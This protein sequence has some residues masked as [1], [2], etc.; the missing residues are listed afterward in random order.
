MT[1]PNIVRKH[2]T[3]STALP[4]FDAG[5]RAVTKLGTQV[6]TGYVHMGTTVA[7]AAGKSLTTVQQIAGRLWRQVL[8]ST[9][10]ASGRGTAGDSHRTHRTHRTE[11]VKPGKIKTPITPARP[12]PAPNGPRHTERRYSKTGT[13][14]S[15]T[16]KSDVA[17]AAK[18]DRV[19]A[20]VDAY[21]K[22]LALVDEL[23]KQS[24]IPSVEEQM[25]ADQRATELAARRSLARHF[26]NRERYPRLLAVPAVAASTDKGPETPVVPVVIARAVPRPAN[27]RVLLDPHYVIGLYPDERPSLPDDIADMNLK[28]T[29]RLVLGPGEA[30]RRSHG[31]IA[32]S[33]RTDS[34]AFVVGGPEARA[35]RRPKEDGA[36]VSSTAQGLRE[37]I[38][39]AAT[40][41]PA[42]DAQPVTPVTA[43]PNPTTSPAASR[44]SYPMG[45]I[46]L[47]GRE[48]R[49]SA[50]TGQRPF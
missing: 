36:R 29:Q 42:S 12:R 10:V 27:K 20:E 46:D 4:F 8:R 47:P 13:T 44:G 9:Q 11:T 28:Y 6:A 41:P 7:S 32:R 48:C 50:G 35:L 37:T 49:T 43:G 15:R 3:T 40:T 24:P 23:L 14:P 16:T 18:R 38:E 5:A 39:A 34:D 21:R 45:A 25:A 30:P 33:V 22:S 19:A 1:G 26:G 2:A 31:A 17:V